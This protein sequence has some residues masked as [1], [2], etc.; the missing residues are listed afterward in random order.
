MSVMNI[1]FKKGVKIKEISNDCVT[2]S[3]GSTLYDYHV[4]DCCE[5]VYA[6]WNYL[7]QESSIKFVEQIKRIEVYLLRDTGIE[8]FF[9]TEDYEKHRFFVPCYNTQNGYY[10]GELSLIF[11]T[12]N[13]FIEAD[14]QEAT[15]FSDDI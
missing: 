7:K 10:S 11:S 5:E 1:N 9:H 8:L 2:F 4:Q 13:F 6:D 3:D 15:K 12:G 14:I